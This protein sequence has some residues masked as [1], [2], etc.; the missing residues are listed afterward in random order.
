[1]KHEL[2][3]KKKF[4]KAEP[5]ERKSS[6]VNSAVKTLIS[7]KK[8]KTIAP[9]PKVALK[10]KK[11]TTVLTA[12]SVKKSEPKTKIISAKNAVQTSKPRTS[13]SEK[14]VSP[15]EVKPKKALKTTVVK[16]E[17]AQ[18]LKQLKSDKDIKTT[19]VKSPVSA[20]KTLPKAKKIE[21]AASD[22]T[23]AKAK[24]PK[25]NVTTKNLK[26]VNAKAEPPKAKDKKKSVEK[27]APK[28]SKSAPIASVK[29][30][31]PIK[32]ISKK[33]ELAKETK[34]QAKSA[35]AFV[36]PSKPNAPKTKTASKEEIELI[37][38]KIETEV[39]PSLTKP[40]KKKAKPISSAVFRGR[41]DKYDFKV[42]ELN[43]RFEQIPAVYV[44]SRRITDKRKKGHHA[45]IC[46]G[47][48]DSIVDEIKKHRKGRCLR[49]NEANV[50][51]I[52]PETDELKR[53]KI[54]TDLKSAHSIQCN[55]K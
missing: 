40:K 42:F 4:A 25:A 43:E 45:L 22:K 24:I 16:T 52:L 30:V 55:L 6:T 26:I 48:T 47:Q 8:T 32:A 2:D 27:I 10:P 44:I 20:K 33:Q 34:P 54:E 50:I 23:D 7:E 36:S 28:T 46:I 41:K 17:K 13:Q 35:K 3:K 12:S 37:E 9:K 29:K 14:S 18:K 38:N 31:E 15:V 53:Q 51:S 19:V 39:A 5:R 49:K 21:M 11:S 1:M